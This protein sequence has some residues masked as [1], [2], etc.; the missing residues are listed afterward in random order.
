MAPLVAPHA[1]LYDGNE[2]TTQCMLETL[3]REILH[4]VSAVVLQ[5]LVNS[6]DERV[7]HYL[8]LYLYLLTI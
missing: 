5:T 1:V 4:A 7:Q 2:V 3:S 8:Y 6:R